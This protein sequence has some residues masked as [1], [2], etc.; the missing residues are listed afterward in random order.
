MRLVAALM[1]VNSR[2]LKGEARRAGAEVMLQQ[3]VEA[4]AAGGARSA[5]AERVDLLRGRLA[6]AENELLALEAERARLDAELDAAERMMR[7]A[8]S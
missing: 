2:H 4:E 5:G 1:D 7:A 3:A 8:H 6:E